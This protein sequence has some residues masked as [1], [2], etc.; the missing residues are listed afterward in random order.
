MTRRRLLLSHIRRV[1]ISTLASLL[2]LIEFSFDRHRFGIS[3]F[4]TI[5]MTRGTG[6]DR[7]VRRQTARRTRTGDVDVTGRALGNVLALAAFVRK[8]CRDA[9][10]SWFGNK[11]RRRFVTA[12][13]IIGNR[14]LIFP[15]TVET[16]IVAAGH[17]LVGMQH[18]W[19]RVRRRQSNN[20]QSHVRLMT[21]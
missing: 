8:L 10:L 5:A 7:N 6:V 3:R 18:C 16:R 17:R 9:L 19:I 21:D 12:R 4:L 13:A 1:A 2:E 14:L 11:S 20:R 15:V